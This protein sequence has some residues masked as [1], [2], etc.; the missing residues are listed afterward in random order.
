MGNNTEYG[1]STEYFAELEAE[2]MVSILRR[3]ADDWFE[4]ITSNNYLDKVKRCWMAYHGASNGTDGHNITF[5]GEQEELVN[6]SIN[7]FRNIAQHL[8]VMITANRP[9]FKARASN[10]DYKSVVQANLANNLLDY[11][12]RDKRLEKVLRLATESAISMGSGFI[13]MSW[14]STTGKIYDYNEETNTPI[15]EGDI[16]FTNHT[17]FDIV[18]DSTK[19]TTEMDW[20]IVRSWKNKFDLAAKYP[21]LSDDIRKLKTKS[22]LTQFKTMGSAYDRTVDIPVYEFFHK[23]SESVPEGRHTIYLDDDIVIHDSPLPYR[24][25]PLYRISPA[26]ILGTPYGYTP[27]FDLL[28]PQ[29]AV[30]SLYSTVLTNQNAFGV[31]NIYVPRGADI[32]LNQ[33]GGGLNIIEGNPQAGK[34]EALNL[35]ET[36][37]EIFEFIKQLESVMETLSG[38]NSVARGNPE[39]SLKSGNALALIQSQALEFVSGLQQQYIQLLED[40]GTGM[41][42]ILR[43]FASVPRVAAIVGEQ[44]RTEM[45]EFSGDD[46][47]EVN[48]VI[49]DVGNALAQTAAGRVQIAEQL[50]QMMPEQLTP[51]QYINIMNTGN[52][53]TLTS[54]MNDEL[55]LIRSENERLVDGRI[56]IQA[57]ATDSHGLHIK[58]HK[59][60]LSDPQL[61][62]DQELTERTLQHIQDHIRL[63]Q[64][65][66]PNLLAMLGEQPL[67]PPGGSPPSQ[68]TMQ[69]GGP[70]QSSQGGPQAT[71]DP[72]AAAQAANQVG[73]LPQPAQ[74]AKSP[75]GAPTQ[76]SQLPL[77]SG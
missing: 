44:N 51:Q 33:L 26:D 76:A 14:N 8:L 10:T 23:R 38:V 49:V 39:A 64:E 66:D 43:D 65:T 59:S 27:M 55:S 13:K 36:P 48:R 30:N 37:R 61:R 40:I 28:A 21:E 2:E 63:L 70:P 35:T 17:I 58:E 71:P 52:I 67:G 15:Y 19:E 77:T 31:Q 69:Q 62:Q 56:K 18:V 68:E 3:K 25:I 29:D 9:A 16:V 42:N 1:S 75:T 32:S 47:S 72:L 34:P 24:D 74:P 41:I 54:A 20:V 50:L 22:E 53:D 57:I 4:T 45:K 11:Y 7:H 12:M 46:L 60:V 5:S 6:I 73:S